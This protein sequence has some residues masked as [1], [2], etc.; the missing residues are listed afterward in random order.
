MTAATARAAT[1][2]AALGDQR[3]QRG[4]AGAPQGHGQPGEATSWDAWGELDSVAPLTSQIICAHWKVASFC[5]GWYGTPSSGWEHPG[6]ELWDVCCSYQSSLVP[7]QC[8]ENTEHGVGRGAASPFFTRLWSHSCLSLGSALG[9]GFALQGKAPASGWARAEMASRLN[10]LPH[11]QFKEIMKS[12]KRWVR[13]G[14]HLPS[15][16]IFWG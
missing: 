16:H 14:F 13:A 6:W 11:F 8:P 7:F 4:A 5:T 1:I 15:M 12:R 10:Q 2:P 9:S 3:S